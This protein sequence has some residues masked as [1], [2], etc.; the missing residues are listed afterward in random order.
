[1]VVPPPMAAPCTAATSGFSKLIN[2]W[3]NCAC[4]LSPGA[5]GFFIKSSISLPALNE[6][7]AA[8]QSTTRIWSSF[9]APLNNSA[10]VMYMLEVIAFFFV[11]RFSWM[12]RMFPERSA[13]MSLIFGLQYVNLISPSPER[14]HM[15][16][17]DAGREVGLILFRA[18][19]E[20]VD[21]Q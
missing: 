11:G 6:F 10:M 18:Y 8:C 9:A 5:G 4:G 14:A 12:L 7:P 1:M 2:A 17:M 21:P 13:T 15:P 16:V 20:R 3:I 19:S